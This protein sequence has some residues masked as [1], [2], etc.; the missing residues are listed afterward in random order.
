MKC[1]AFDRIIKEICFS[2]NKVKRWLNDKRLTVLEKKI[3]VGHLMI[4]D[5]Q[6]SEVIKSFENISLS[7]LDFVNAHRNLLLG[8]CFNNLS[9]FINAE[10]FLTQ[11][12][13]EFDK[14]NLTY[15]L[16]TTEFNLF[17]VY[18][19]TSDHLGMTK[20][21]EKMRLFA[22]PGVLQQSRLMRCEFICAD[23][24]ENYLSAK[25]WSNQLKPILG[26]MSESD[27]I[28]HLVSEFMFYIR[29]DNHES[30]WRTIEFMKKYRKFQLSE[31]FK[32]MQR[33]LKNF[34][35]DS[36]IY[37]YEREFENVPLLLHQ[38]KV[39]QSLASHDVKEVEYH[40]SQLQLIAPS[41][42]GT[43]LIYKGSK[44]LFSI[45]L[46]KYKS[47]YDV[48]DFPSHKGGSQVKYLYQLLQSTDSPLNKEL[49]FKLIWGEEPASKDDLKR[50]GRLVSKVREKY[51]VEIK[52]RMGAYYISNPQKISKAS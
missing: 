39:I 51:G 42:Y 2:P 16:F 9:D 32:F 52:S 10:R 46:E 11:A 5:N 13:V 30:A 24:T 3:V 8:I 36:P 47:S 19:N 48:S 4:R 12:S 22:Q 41:S 25:Y 50:L 23:E 33:L 40:W 14:L 37:A 35:D 18:S 49:V 17:M 6:N 45:C 1:K 7:E 21:L 44:C 38:L 28:A 20:S 26:K 34:L 43:D 31:N 27:Q 15:H 29:N